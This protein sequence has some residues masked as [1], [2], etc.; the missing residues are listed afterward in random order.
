MAILTDRELA[1]LRRGLRWM[2]KEQLR[3]F[4]QAL[5][6]DEASA[7]G[8]G[9]DVADAHTLADELRSL[10]QDVAREKGWRL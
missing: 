1:A 7:P 4:L 10:V 9:I 8:R 3:G 5:A 6:G 2:G